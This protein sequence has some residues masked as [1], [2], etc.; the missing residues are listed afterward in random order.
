MWVFEVCTVCIFHYVTQPKISRDCAFSC[1]SAIKNKNKE[2]RRP[3]LFSS[4]KYEKK[5]DKLP[6]AWNKKYQRLHICRIIILW[7]LSS[8]FQIEYI[9]L[10]VHIPI[11]DHRKSRSYFSRIEID[12]C[13]LPGNRMSKEVPFLFI[14]SFLTFSKLQGKLFSYDVLL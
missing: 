2:S 14:V 9:H 11:E 6:H 8:K 13:H 5:P 1:N 3:M 4:R 10:K 12:F 7:Y